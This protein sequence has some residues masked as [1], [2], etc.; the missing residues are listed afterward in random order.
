MRTW[1]IEGSDSNGYGFS[2]VSNDGYVCSVYFDGSAWVGY[3]ATSDE[4][5]I[6]LA[7]AEF[8]R[9]L[10]ADVELWADTA[11]DATFPQQM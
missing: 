8:G 10:T 1:K 6:D 2:L 9:M 11:I 4:P 5:D 7:A 3:I